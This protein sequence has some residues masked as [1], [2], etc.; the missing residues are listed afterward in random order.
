MATKRPTPKKTITKKAVSTGPSA[1]EEILNSAVPTEQTAAEERKSLPQAGAKKAPAKK[2]A[3]KKVAKPR[4]ATKSVA[5]KTEVVKPKA[6]PD[7][8]EDRP[9]APADL[10]AEISQVAYYRW[11]SRGRTEGN[12]E[13]DWFE[14]E[15]TVRSRYGL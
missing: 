6:Q 7:K 8:P 2:T 9:V 14:A 5:K 13:A 10:T 4:S 12:A 3:V 15:M 1:S 11:E